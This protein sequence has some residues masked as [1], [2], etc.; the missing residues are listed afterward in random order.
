MNYRIDPNAGDPAYI[1]L[2]RQLVRDIVSGV[3]PYGT[4]LP[5]K[6]TVAAETGVSTITVE[7]AVELLT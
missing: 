7:H 3:Y 5:S 6:R 4:K 1:Q 2:Y